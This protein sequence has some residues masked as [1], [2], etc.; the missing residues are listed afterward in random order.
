MNIIGLNGAGRTG[1]DTVREIIGQTVNRRVIREAFADR[2]K[3]SAARALGLSCGQLESVKDTGFVKVQGPVNETPHVV[4]VRSYLERYGHEAHRG[5]FGE[6]FWIA[7][8]MLAHDHR[9]GMEPPPLTVVTD[10]RFKNEAEA[11]RQRGG[12]VWEVLRPQSAVESQHISNQPLPRHLIDRVIDNSG[13]LEET[14]T[15]VKHALFGAGLLKQ[16]APP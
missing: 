16:V 11:V 13:S 8:V 3:E 4:A 10:L 7:P 1:K 12:E 6:D 15:M 14:T 9:M 5:V 2:L